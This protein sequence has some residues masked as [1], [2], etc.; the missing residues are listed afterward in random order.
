MTRTWASL[1]LLGALAMGCT[2]PAQRRKEEAAHRP[3]PRKA[4]KRPEL[5]PAPPPPAP[6][7]APPL[8]PSGVP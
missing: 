4:L 7:P 5:A 3:P 1:V 2:S 6:P 8:P